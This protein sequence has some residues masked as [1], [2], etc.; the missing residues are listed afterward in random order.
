MGSKVTKVAE[1]VATDTA[2][3]LRKAA[4]SF[5]SVIPGTPCGKADITQ[6]CARR[7]TQYY[8]YLQEII[9]TLFHYYIAMPTNVSYAD[10]SC[11]PPPPPPP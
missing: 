11:A 10:Y 7:F 1:K 9:N 8:I 6:L 3:D 4:G 5:E 2:E